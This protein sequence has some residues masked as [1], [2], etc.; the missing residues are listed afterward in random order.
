VLT[1]RRI[2]AFELQEWIGSGGMGEVYRAR[3]TKLDRDVAVKILPPSV[4][5][6][7]QRLARFQRE[8]RL[9]AAV[10][11]PHIAAIYGIEEAAGLTAIVMELVDGETLAD[12]I[13]RGPPPVTDAVEWARQIATAMD[14]AH[15]KGIVHRDLKPANI[16]ITRTGDV[17]V[18]DFGLAKASADDGAADPAQS[19]TITAAG[20]RDGVILGTAAYLSPEQARGQK[21]DKRADIWAFGCVL[22]EMLTG[23][24]AFAR[25]TVT[26]TLV[27]ILEKDPDWSALPAATPPELRRALERCLQK[28]PKRRLRDIGDLSLKTEAATAAPDTTARRRYREPLGWVVAAVSL[29]ALAL[30][31][32]PGRDPHTDALPA[33][34]M[35]SIIPL[36]ADGRLAASDTDHPIAISDDGARIAYVSESLGDRQLFI[37]EL[38]NLQA[39]PIP[40]ARGART[41]FFSPDGK[42]LAF[43]ADGALQKVAVNNAAPQRICAA[44]GVPMGGSWGPD[45]TIVWATRG[46]PLRRVNAGGGV[47][48]RIEP[49][50]FAAWPQIL[51]D[52]KTILFTAINS[53]GAGFQIGVVSFDGSNRRIIA[54][55]P[56]SPDDGPPVLSSGG[57]LA[58]ARLLSNGYLLYGQSR[59]PGSVQGIQ[60]DPVSLTPI[61]SSTLLVDSIERGRNS[62]GVY[63]AVSAGGLLVYAGTGE[64]HQLVWVDRKGAVSPIADERAAFRQPRLS[65]DGK[66]IAVAANDDMRRSNLWIYDAERGTRRRLGAGLSL[67]WT[68]DGRHLTFSSVGVVEA[69]AAGGERVETLLPLEQIRAHLPAG[70]NAYATSWSPDGRTLLMQS[71]SLGV[72]VLQRG[73]TEPKA[74]FKDHSE[75]GAQFSPDGKWIAYVSRESGRNEVYVRRY[76]ELTDTVAVSS[77]GGAFPQWSRDGR[78]IF[79]RQGDALVAASIDTRAGLH[80]GKPRVLFAGHFTGVGGDGS[81]SVTP[82]GQR[83]VMI[84]SDEAS[85]LQQLTL[86]QNWMADLKRR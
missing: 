82:D 50:G 60:L 78:E 21:V 26:D 27:A 79:F 24:L 17:K 41:P 33:P 34:V 8:A 74:L 6:D 37:R 39:T 86:V 58:Q 35:R 44:D 81:F 2:G 64:R 13:R 42:W 52:G 59:N 83:F 15:E 55:T 20:T 68:P 51:P 77:D 61:G 4:S 85:A 28:D 36:G 71:D 57:A 53:V 19:P 23:R 75:W 25:D 10:S 43:F 7:S 11:H 62:G 47:A 31:A 70:T 38:G 18:L 66:L 16:K 32:W 63:F 72:W 84:R 3:D 45:D 65:P 1:G 48:Q 46:L 69:P 80:A 73:Q 76:P 56:E 54:R 5:H 29:G 49:A 9:L 40:G 30:L 67:A 12:I 22:Y 14:A